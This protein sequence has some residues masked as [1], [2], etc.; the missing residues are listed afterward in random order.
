MRFYPGTVYW[1]AP[2]I[3]ERD[4]PMMIADVV[5]ART[6]QV[7]MRMR[8]FLFRYHKANRRICNIT[9]RQNISLWRRAPP[10]YH[11]PSAIIHA[12]RP[13]QPCH[14]K[15]RRQLQQQ[16]YLERVISGNRF[17]TYNWMHTCLSV[18][19][20]AIHSGELTESESVGEKRPDVNISLAH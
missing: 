18:N 11:L 20:W 19:H 5:D 12:I 2:V 13:V 3:C 17:V 6:K 9:R 14:W 16:I 4:I 7:A 1:D 10:S 15:N 8:I